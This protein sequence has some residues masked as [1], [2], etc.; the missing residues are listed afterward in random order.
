M[1][2]ESKNC[3]P[4]AVYST[5]Q[6]HSFWEDVVACCLCGDG[7][8]YKSSHNAEPVRKGRCCHVC[9]MEIVIP[10]RFGMHIININPDKLNEKK[11]KKKNNNR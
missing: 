9:N 2:K 11:N 10:K 5:H 6:T 7:I 8:K 3:F 1:S 4:E